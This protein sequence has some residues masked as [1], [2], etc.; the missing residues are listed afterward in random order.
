MVEFQSFLD[1][2]HFFFIFLEIFL[3]GNL[4]KHM[5]LPFWVRRDVSHDF[6]CKEK[7]TTLASPAGSVHAERETVALFQRR[8]DLVLIRHLRI[9]TRTRTHP[10]P[11][12]T[13][14][15]IDV[16]ACYFGWYTHT[17][18]KRVAISIFN[19]H[20]V[21]WKNKFFFSKGL[22]L[23]INLFFYLIP[24]F[25]PFKCAEDPKTP[26]ILTLHWRKM[27]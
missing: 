23:K 4:E 15:R 21:G 7:K 10:L 9:L 22:R 5:N 16:N 1:H 26:K 8:R 18:G 27:V 20:R 11:L 17:L 3:N 12:L 24:F 2:F 6:C 25:P 19:M 14:L 13:I